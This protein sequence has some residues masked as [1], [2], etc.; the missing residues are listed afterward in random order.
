MRT[1]SHRAGEFVLWL[2]PLAFALLGHLCAW[3]KA[4]LSDTGPGWRIL[5]MNERT[6]RAQEAWH[7]L[8]SNW[9][10]FI[11]YGVVLAAAWMLLIAKGI[12]W[13]IRL[14]VFALLALP[15]LWYGNL[16]IYL[17]GKLLTVG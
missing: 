2:L 13:P 6:L 9:W 1:W 15:G 12:W 17:A 4:E 10:L 11:A 7:V 5:L 14:G 3:P 8:N 16:S